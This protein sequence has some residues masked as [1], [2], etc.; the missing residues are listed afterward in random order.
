VLVQTHLGT[1]PTVLAIIGTSA[2]L[3][4]RHD[5]PA[6]WGS[7]RAIAVPAVFVVIL[8]FPPLLEQVTRG[9]GN[10][11][12]I[13]NFFRAGHPGQP[14]GESI[15]IVGSQLRRFP[16][17]RGRVVNDPVPLHAGDSILVAAYLGLVLLIVLVGHRRR[18]DFAVRIGIVSGVA[19]VTSVLAVSRI[20]G[21]TFD[22]LL[23]WISVLTV[24]LWLAAAE[25]V[26]REW[27]STPMARQAGGVALVVLT[28]LVTVP[29]IRPVARG[30]LGTPDVTDVRTSWPEVRAAL[31]SPRR[32]VLIRIV[33]DNQWSMGAGLT[34]QLEKAGWAVSVTDR[35]LFMFGDNYR[36]SGEERVAVELRDGSIDVV[37]VGD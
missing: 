2:I 5:R 6:G 22:F 24:P 37:A 31:G 10:L 20:T 36:A 29:V 23:T 3:A 28:A 9:T 27:P 1:A 33:D 17:G 7:P 21:G 25:L 30:V 4:L 14:I 35:W 18:D 26:V 12:L 34:L 19:L 8:W 15:A 16:F 11:G 32:A 13:L